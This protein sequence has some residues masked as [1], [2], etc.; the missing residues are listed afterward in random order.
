MTH[1]TPV[2]NLYTLSYGRGADVPTWYF[3]LRDEFD[4]AVNLMV[5]LGETATIGTAES[6]P[7]GDLDSDFSE[8]KSYVAL[9]YPHITKDPK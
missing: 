5:S 7:A 9:D 8:F 2:A 1:L 4:K 6:V 3:S